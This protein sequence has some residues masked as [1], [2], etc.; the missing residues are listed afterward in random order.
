MITCIA[1]YS[2]DKMHQKNLHNN[3]KFHISKFHKW[4]TEFESGSF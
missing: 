4:V 2:C 1:K 3:I